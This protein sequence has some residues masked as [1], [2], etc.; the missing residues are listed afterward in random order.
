MLGQHTVLKVMDTTATVDDRFLDD[1]ALLRWQRS[2]GLVKT[3]QPQVGRRV[4][5]AILIAWLPLAIL[6]GVSFVIWSDESSSSF[7]FDFGV[8]ARFLVAVPAFIFAE[9]ECLPRLRTIARHFVEAGLITD[10][11]KPRFLTVLASTRSLIESTLGDLV[12]ILIVY[13]TVA[14]LTVYLSTGSL[15]AWHRPETAGAMQLSL[16]GWWHALVSLPLLLA[17]LIGWLWRIALWWRFLFL[18]SK[19]NLHLIPSHP[20]HAGGLKFVSASLRGFRVVSFALGAVVAGSLANLQLYRSRD[21]DLADARN[22]VIGLMVFLAII[23]AGPLSIF[24]R[25]LREAK[26]TGIFQYG[27]LA[28]SVGLRFEEKWLQ[29]GAVDQTAL[30]APD[31][32]ATTDLYGVARNAYEMKE[33]P[34][35]LKD[36]IGPVL[37]SGSIPFLPLVVMAM[38]IEAIFRLIL[39]L[40]F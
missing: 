5:V 27:A 36:L 11:D 38:P 20:D 10:A 29:S 19:L 4:L 39:N 26:K 15:V 37:I 35:D 14:A 22:L 31:F 3:D 33:L 2:V 9:S 8:H 7:F 21:L 23:L 17:I 24:V 28:G 12:T 30:E 13:G 34:F 25:T 40:L 18:V 1:G 32:S 16:A 6:S